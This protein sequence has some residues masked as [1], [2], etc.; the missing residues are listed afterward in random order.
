MYH[1]IEPYIVFQGKKKAK[2]WMQIAEEE[3]QYFRMIQEQQ[4]IQQSLQSSTAAPGGWPINNLG[5]FHPNLSTLGFSIS[6]SQTGS[7]PY[8]VFLNNTSNSDVV[9]F[10]NFTWNFGDGT[11]DNNLTTTKTFDTGSFKISLTASSQY[12]NTTSSISMYITASLPVVISDFTGS[13]PISSS[14]TGAM[15]LTNLSYITNY[16]SSNGTL[17][18][19][20]YK[21]SFGSGSI[22]STSLNSSITYTVTGAYAVKLEATGSYGIMSNKTTTYY[23]F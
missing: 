20:T 9:R 18:G 22:T 12:N 10:C 5:Y 14:I 11:S 2:H 7:A 19:V 6:P 23:K 16:T 8:T 21:W 17:P 15:D 13:L 1:I 3:Q 4:L